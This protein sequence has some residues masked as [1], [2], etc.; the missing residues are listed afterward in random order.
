M[1]RLGRIA[2]RAER[3]RIS[4]EE[5]VLGAS[6]IAGSPGYPRDEAWLL[7][8]ARRSEK[9]PMDEGKNIRQ[10]AAFQASGDRRGELGQIAVP[11]LVLHGE[12]DPMFPLRAGR[13]TADAIPG[14][15]FVSYPGM[16]HDL[17]RELWPMMVDEIAT[18]VARAPSAP[19]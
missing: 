4:A 18:T 13:A 2:R 15:R 19:E 17:P 10:T 1:V 3:G 6:R 12:A 16:G 8:S 11:T 9:Y 14:A 5:A 7:E